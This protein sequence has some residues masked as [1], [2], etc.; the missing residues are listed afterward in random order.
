M[1]GTFYMTCFMLI[2]FN[3]RLLFYMKAKNIKSQSMVG[4]YKYIIILAV[5][6]ISYLYRAVY[7]TLMAFTPFLDDL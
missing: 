7:D 3:L 4:N 6:S 2:Y 1:A 5:F